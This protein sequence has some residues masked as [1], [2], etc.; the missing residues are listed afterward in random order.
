[1]ANENYFFVVFNELIG[2]QNPDFT[3]NSLFLKN[4]SP[5]IVQT[6]KSNISQKLYKITFAI[7]LLLSKKN[8]FHKNL[9]YEIILQKVNFFRFFYPVLGASST[10]GGKTKKKRLLKING[11]L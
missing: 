5:F 2:I 4:F 7:F 11:G 8:I 6:S 10:F 1:M 9:S 3:Q